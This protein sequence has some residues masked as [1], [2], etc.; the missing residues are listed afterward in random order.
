M[1][2]RLQRTRGMGGHAINDDWRFIK[3]YV[4]RKGQWQVVAWQ[5]SES[6]RR[7]LD[8]LLHE[9]P[10]FHIASLARMNSES[11]FCRSPHTGHSRPI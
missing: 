4:R 6:A 2:G 9:L 3:V 10:S 1:T 8:H 7:S 5:A 11:E